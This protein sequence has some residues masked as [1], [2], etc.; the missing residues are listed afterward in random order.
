[1]YMP[2]YNAE[3]VILESHITNLLGDGDT[4]AGKGG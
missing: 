2:L 1:M 3:W 4:G